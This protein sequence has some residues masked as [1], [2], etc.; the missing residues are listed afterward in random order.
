MSVLPFGNFLTL[1]QPVTTTVSAVQ[2]DGG[3]AQFLKA[4]DSETSDRSGLLAAPENASQPA[5]MSLLSLATKSNTG[6][7]VLAGETSA[8][9][10]ETA[11]ASKAALSEQSVISSQASDLASAATVTPYIYNPALT[12]QIV[13]PAASSGDVSGIAISAMTSPNLITAPVEGVQLPATQVN[14]ASSTAVPAADPSPAAAQTVSV[15][16][17]PTATTSASPSTT[18]TIATQVDLTA[19]TLSTQT[20]L[21]SAQ[22]TTLPQTTAAALAQITPVAASGSP[23]PVS[24][25]AALTAQ[26]ANA[27]TAAQTATVQQAVPQGILKPTSEAAQAT[28]Q[29]G[30][31]APSVA[32]QTRSQTVSTSVPAT[33]AQTA[34]LVAAQTTAPSAPALGLQVT[35]TI[36]P[37]AQQAQTNLAA[38]STNK[39]GTS[40]KT[41]ASE[42]ASSATATSGQTKSASAAQP[43][44]QTVQP[45]AVAANAQPVL[46]GDALADQSTSDLPADTDLADLQLA[47]LSQTAQKAADLTAPQQVKPATNSQLAAV[48]SQVNQRILERFDGKNSK[49]EIRLDPAELGKIDVKI[50]VDGDGRVQAV[51]AASDA[52]AADALTRGLR[53]LENALTQAGLSLSDNGLRVEINGRNSNQSSAQN[54][55]SGEQS[56]NGSAGSED[57]TPTAEAISLNAPEIQVWSQSRLDIRA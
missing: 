51:L 18:A 34:T 52:T 2:D 39:T 31:T 10:I 7:S 43:S 50:E 36:A 11:A 12:S 21:A 6:S 33:T 23:D 19:P 42:Q 3:F 16:P 9:V 47:D 54:D 48:I 30:S 45:Q 49:F 1:G 41:E 38:Q 35:E 57:D 55:M 32:A 44:S 17:A 56:S 24:Q 15:T 27:P 29:T 14:A 40:L 5:A 20:S 53:S 22:T 37:L 13:L 26:T 25:S 46:T 4:A 28:T 8:E